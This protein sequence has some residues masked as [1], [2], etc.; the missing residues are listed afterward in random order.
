MLG[1]LEILTNFA[2]G[3]VVFGRRGV[4]VCPASA[5]FRVVTWLF[6]Y[7][8]PDRSNGARDLWHVIGF[9]SSFC[10]LVG[11]RF[12]FGL[13]SRI[14]RSTGIH[15]FLNC[16]RVHALRAIIANIVRCVGVHVIR[17]IVAKIVRFASL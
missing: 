3:G 13:D 9:S 1:S 5:S 10:V 14:K 11:S 2:N 15:S 8:L 12:N 6:E 17:A 7:L 16:D 4:S